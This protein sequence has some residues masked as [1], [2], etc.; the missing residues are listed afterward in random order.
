MQ[1][2]KTLQILLKIL[3]FGQ[4]AVVIVLVANFLMRFNRLGD[5]LVGFYEHRTTQTAFGIRSLSES[6]FNPLA[7]EMP[8]LGPPWKVPFEFPLF[9][10]L[11]AILVRLR[12]FD[13]GQAGRFIASV[14][15]LVIGYLVYR[16]GCNVRGRGVGL[17]GCILTVFSA[18]GLLVGSEVL[19][20]GFALVGALWAFLII[21]SL[22]VENFHFWSIFFIFLA[23]LISGLVKLNTTVIWVL[24]ALVFLAVGSQLN[25][26]RRLWVI[27][28]LF[29]S[30]IPSF[31]WTSYADSVKSQGKYS[32]WL[33]SDRLN[34]WY[35]GTLKDRFDFKTISGSLTQFTEAS[36]GGTFVLI[37][38]VFLAFS[39]KENRAIALSLLV[40]LIGGPLI[41]I[42][43]YITHPYY[44]TAV[45]PAA[46]LLACL[47][48]ANLADLLK[49][50]LEFRLTPALF[51]V[52]VIIVSSSYLSNT[53]V[54]YMDLFLY[55]RPVPDVAAVIIDETEPDDLLIV[56]G[57]DWSPATHF[58]SNRRGLAL[59]Q[60]SPKPEASE[61]G[62]T[63]RYV[64]TWDSEPAWG[65]YFPKDTKLIEV[66]ER[67][68]RIESD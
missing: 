67:L 59:R 57:D 27:A 31:I 40:V 20:D 37:V 46:V 11:A 65:D 60:D 16:I 64:Y 28:A 1:L 56:I 62:T 15:F 48:L 8:T 4:I 9:Q 61:L 45:L 44:W 18:F 22:R 2:K 38:L 66:G 21:V 58:Y 23:T 55:R 25:L 35:F 29:A 6:T 41:F 7:A 10:W 5:P 49:K 54:S 3:S 12:L 52:A 34:E 30:L 53:G 51:F 43:L 19:I 33:V 17:A 26:R 14:S 63:Y 36:V 50:H 47:G 24:G 39:R 13:V 32:S 68:Y 42:R